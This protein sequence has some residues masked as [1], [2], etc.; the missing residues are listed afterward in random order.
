MTGLLRADRRP[1]LRLLTR[2]DPADLRVLA[3]WGWT[4]LAVLVAAWAGAYLATRA[5]R[6]LPLLEQW[7]QWD[8]WHFQAV[9]TGGYVQDGP[10]PYA[11]FFPGLPLL[12]RALGWT[13]MDLTAAGLLVSAV[14]GAVAMLALARLASL[15]TDD[16]RPLP[17]GMGERAVLLLLVSPCAVF[18]AAGYTESLFLAFA[19][20]AWLSARRGHWLAAGLLAA[21]AAS[22]RVT[23]IFL[24][25]ALLV[26]WATQRGAG[27]ARA[28]DARELAALLLAFLPAVAF[29]VYLRAVTGDWLAFAHAQQRGWYRELTS[30]VE[31]WRATWGAAFGGPRPVAELLTFRAEL[32][33]MLVGVLLLAWLVRRRAWGESTYV[34][35]QVVAFATSTWFFSVPRATL[36]WWPLW[37]VIARVTL[38][39]PWTL[40]AYLAVSLPLAVLWVAAFTTGRWAG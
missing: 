7:R 2:A 23:G 14:A 20:P 15:P 24:A 27:R 17:R 6:V 25:V 1:R 3:V 33:A 22:V 34:G 35:L 29:T 26:Q 5:D 30:P 11:A 32:V 39:R 40:A 28:R 12:L 36:L 38:R 21:G 31:A 13:G 4:R 9:A 19:L 37:V 18:L 8:V 16:G 10:T